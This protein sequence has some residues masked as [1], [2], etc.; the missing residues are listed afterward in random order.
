MSADQ[1]VFSLHFILTKVQEFAQIDGSLFPEDAGLTIDYQSILP[2]SI[3]ETCLGRFGKNS[4]QPCRQGV[5]GSPKW[6]GSRGG[7]QGQNVCRLK[8]G[9]LLQA[10]SP[11][12]APQRPAN[13]GVCKAVRE[14]KIPPADT[15]FCGIGWHRKDMSKNLGF[16]PNRLLQLNPEGIHGIFIRNKYDLKKCQVCGMS[17]VACSNSAMD[18]KAEAELL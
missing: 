17:F 9:W 18:R 4:L 5:Q 15:G 6:M 14:K 2:F 3:L 12:K 16:G 1:A 8:D 10:S 13:L 7:G 11:E